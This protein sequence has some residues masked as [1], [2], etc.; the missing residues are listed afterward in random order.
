MERRS[1]YPLQNAQFSPSQTTPH[2]PVD[3]SRPRLPRTLRAVRNSEDTADHPRTL[4]I[5]LDGTGDQ[6]DSDNSNVVHFVSCLKKHSPGEQVTYYQSGIGTY[7]AGGL[8]NGFAAGL[9]MAIG[10]GLGEPGNQH[11]R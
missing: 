8:K 10:S 11:F 9:D 2:N 4:V 3:D 1:S 5:C 6:F 7:D